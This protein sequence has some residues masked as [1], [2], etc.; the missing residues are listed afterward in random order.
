MRVPTEE[1]RA[2]QELAADVVDGSGRLLLPAGTTLTDK[3]IRYFQMWGISEVE[4]AGGDG[5]DGRKETPVDPVRL[6]EVRAALAPRF[7]HVDLEHPGMAA[8]FNHC[9]NTALAKRP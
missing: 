2:D 7:A 5:A 6:E 8:L 3:H 4:I 1:L 9:V